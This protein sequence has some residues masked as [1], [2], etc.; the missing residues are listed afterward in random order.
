MNN[1]ADIQTAADE[2]CRLSLLPEIRHISY[3]QLLQY[4]AE[5]VS[6]LLKDD[7]ASLVQLLYRMDIS[8]EKLRYFLANNKEVMAAK[9]IAEL[10]IERQLQKIETRRLFKNNNIIP[11]DEKW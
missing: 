7:F 6:S 10:M 9:I 8:E 3:D 1:S 4:L 2:L 11:D 5:K